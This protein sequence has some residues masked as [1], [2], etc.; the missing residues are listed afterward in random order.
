M[1]FE[2]NDKSLT[3]SSS[4]TSVGKRACRS[5]LNF[6]DSTTES[7]EEIQNGDTNRVPHEVGSLPTGC[8]TN[9]KNPSN[10]LL[11]LYK[12]NRV[13]TQFAPD[14][15]ALIFDVLLTRT[16]TLRHPRGPQRSLSTGK[17]AL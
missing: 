9:K 14:K 8:T 16:E 13:K 1:E 10:S 2:C 12:N 5:G 4:P 7:R 15:N 11:A 17:G 6:P 3:S